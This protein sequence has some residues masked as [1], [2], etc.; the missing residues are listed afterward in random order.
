MFNAHRHYGLHSGLLLELLK[1]AWYAE[2]S[3]EPAEPLTR[4]GGGRLKAAWIFPAA[5]WG[6][7]TELADSVYPSR[8]SLQTFSRARGG[9]EAG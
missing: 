1:G 7:T 2:T 3:S 4:R 5:T 6:G 9:V 8:T